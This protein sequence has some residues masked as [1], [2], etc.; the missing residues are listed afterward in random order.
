MEYLHE[1]GVKMAVA[2]WYKEEHIRNRGL[3]SILENISE[4]LL[5]E[6]K[7]KTQNL[8]P[9]VYL[10]AANK[11]GVNNENSIAIEDSKPGAIGASKSG[12]PTLILPRLINQSTEPVDCSGVQ[13]AYKD[14]FY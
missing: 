13:C 3:K 4:Q 14:Q 2:S 6:K 12:A 10:L 1:I 9:D 8:H 7:W 5:L 11:L